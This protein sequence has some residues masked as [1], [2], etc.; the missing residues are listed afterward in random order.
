MKNHQIQLV[1]IPKVFHRKFKR[2]IREALKYLYITE[3]YIQKDVSVA[4]IFDPIVSTSYSKETGLYG[5]PYKNRDYTT[6]IMYLGYP[7]FELEDERDMTYLITLT[8]VHELMHVMSSGD[9]KTI[10]DLIVEEG[11][12]TWFTSMLV[13]VGPD[14]NV[15]N[16]T[17]GNMRKKWLLVRPFLQKEGI[18]EFRKKFSKEIYE[19]GYF[20]MDE[21]VKKHPK[22]TFRQLMQT[23]RA[24]FR[25]YLHTL[26][27]DT[28]KS[29]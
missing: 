17:E 8:V 26:F 21:Y 13:G 7:F 1:N 27:R 23:R 6:V 24:L 14:F 5:Y 3:E 15:E 19:L 4:I 12:A 2:A 16:I 9:D 10:E 22:L 20:L 18:G 28:V 25:N 11:L 29:K